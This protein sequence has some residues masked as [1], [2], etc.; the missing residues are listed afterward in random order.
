MAASLR[1]DSTL[2]KG[3]A[4]GS[5]AD[6]LD[7]FPGFFVAHRG[8]VGQPAFASLFAGITG[9]MTLAYDG[10][11]LNDPLTGLADLNLV[12]TESVAEMAIL[13]THHGRRL[14][15]YPLGGSLQL[16]STDLA[17][18][19]IKS[20]AGYRTGQN[21]FDDID[22]RLGIRSSPAMAINAGAVLKNYAGTSLNS[23][24]EGQKINARIDRRVFN[25]WNMRYVLLM[26][27]FDLGVPLAHKVFG[28]EDLS[29]P[30][31]K[32]ERQDHGLVLSRGLT[33]A[34]VQYTGLSREFY[35]AGHA[36][37]D[38]VYDARVFRLTG[39]WGRTVGFFNLS[40]GASWH[41][42]SLD[43]S[44]W[45]AART[46]WASDAWLHAA[47]GSGGPL[48]WGGGVRFRSSEGYGNCLHP[49][50]SLCFTPRQDLIFFSWLS[51]N[52]T[53]PSIHSRASLGPF[54]KGSS[55]LRAAE[56]SQAGI[57][58]ERRGRLTLFL[59]LSARRTRDQIARLYDPARDQMP[60]YQNLS[61]Y[62]RISLDGLVR[63]SYGSWL[64]WVLKA[65]YQK[66]QKVE[67]VPLVNTPDFF[68]HTY[69]Q[70]HKI[71]F[72]G[73]LD[74]RLRL[75]TV[76]LSR[77]HGPIPY[78]AEV[79]DHLV[80]MEGAAAP[81][82]HVIFIIKDVTLFAAMQ[83]IPGTDFERLY[84]YTMPKSQFRWGFIW[85]FVD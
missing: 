67:E 40:A 75:G 68:C 51:Q 8:S 6:L 30:H 83:N 85:H 39:Q 77:R 17:D 36:V 24:Y 70:F 2:I 1:G 31:S 19:P 26:N 61:S 18:V 55:D 56:S 42:T 38:Q 64:T 11:I 3:A 32:D 12:P 52:R 63:Y 69:F 54:A 66:Q 65:K 82:A 4:Y 7:H 76:Y 59:T 41:A 29:L 45:G 46:E 78:Y 27:K 15:F 53:Y 60:L 10:L 74:A 84:G 21:G 48:S 73:D 81:F 34:A 28:Y 25:D 79:S 14:G 23:V 44:D 80:P 72:S 37:V 35:G 9:T 50:M 20:R 16:R 5:F 43:S 57:G 47:G 49:E 58:F 71:L 13:S 33:T 62:N 22:I